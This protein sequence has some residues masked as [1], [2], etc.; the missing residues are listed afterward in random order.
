MYNISPYTV[1]LPL[2]LLGFCETDATRPWPL[3]AAGDRW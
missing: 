1:T 3:V 2:G